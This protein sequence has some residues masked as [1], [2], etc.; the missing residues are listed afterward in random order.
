[1]KKKLK[2]V[3]ARL[4]LGVA[5]VVLGLLA[6]EA[7]LRV[8]YLNNRYQL[9]ESH[10][11]LRFQPAPGVMPGIEGT[12][13]FT[14][15]AYGIR[16]LPA[17]DALSTDYRLLAIGGST[18]ET[19]YLDDRESWSYLLQNHLGAGFW[20]GNIGR[21]GDTTATHYY[22]VQRIV[23][24]FAPD[25]VLIMAGINDLTP[26][27]SHPQWQPIALATLPAA[28][29]INTFYRA[30][31]RTRSDTSGVVLLDFLKWEIKNRYFVTNTLYIEDQAGA[32]YEQRRALWRK[33]PPTIDTLPANFD[34]AL[35]AYADNLRRIADA[36]AQQGITLVFINQP[37]VWSA[38]MPAEFE[39]Y[40]WLVQL[41]QREASTARYTIPI[42]AD[43]LA[44]YNAALDAVC[45]ERALTCV[46]LASSMNGQTAFFY[47]D[48]H[49]NEA[50]ARHVAQ[51]I[52]A[53]LQ[54]R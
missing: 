28:N 18:T 33:A 49:F 11:D 17:Y 53:V 21:S 7:L 4:L 30:P 44:Q 39:A 20:V 22:T 42:L 34:A 23:P 24:Q 51:S 54:P 26:A 12:S 29:V 43:A 50:G 10:L 46:D 36:A 5:G 6:T 41:G 2:T 31:Y 16:A 25:V 48:V 52:A 1:M 14:T 19:L 35:A 40:L 38:Q 13:R 47:D 8:F 37:A 9:R 32:F 15:D 27:L 45:R 3:G